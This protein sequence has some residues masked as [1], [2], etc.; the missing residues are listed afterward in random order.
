MKL[1]HAAMITTGLVITTGFA[2]IIPL[3]LQ[4][5]KINPPQLIML[6]FEISEGES[7]QQRGLAIASILNRY[8][9][10]ATVFFTGEVAERYPEVISSFGEKVDIGSQTS[11][12][13]DLTGFTD[14]SIKLQQIRDGKDA[15]DGA[16]SLS[17]KSFRAPFGATDQDIYS[18]LSRSDI[19]ADFSYHD[20]YNV[21]ER[22]QFIKYEA[23]TYWAHDHSPD[24]FLSLSKT[25]KPIII[26]F[27]NDHPVPDIEGL[28]L[29]LLQSDVKL[30]NASELTGLP[31]TT[32]RS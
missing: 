12:N 22:D 31:L 3:F 9:V 4:P 2:M 10:P 29:S 18:L 6:C 26:Y 19:L 30:V 25:T 14:Y 23:L 11:S 13:S 1:K 5:D 27:D 24:F 21:Y 17:S 20:Q 15:V 32:R 7:V 16:G 28:I 8:D